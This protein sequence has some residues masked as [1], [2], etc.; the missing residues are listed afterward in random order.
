LLYLQKQ[1]LVL[2]YANPVVFKYVQV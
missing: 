2:N 1:A